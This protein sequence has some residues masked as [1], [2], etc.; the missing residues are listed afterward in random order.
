MLRITVAFRLLGL[1]PKTRTYQASTSAL[2]VYWITVNHREVYGMH[3]CNGIL[4]NHESPRETRQDA[5][6]HPGSFV[7]EMVAHDREKA[8]KEALLRLKSFKIAGA[9]EG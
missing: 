2:Y 1:T 5:H 8:R 4:F 3:A 9:R 7:A 6:H